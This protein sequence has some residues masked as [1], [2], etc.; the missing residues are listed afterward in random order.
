MP[1]QRATEGKIVAIAGAT[2]NAGRALVKEAKRRG[3][4][5]RALV[6]DETRLG[7]ARAS[8]DEIRVV[9]VTERESLRGALDGATYAL[10]ALGKTFQ[11]DSTPRREVDVDANV[12][13]FDEARRVRVRRAGLMSVYAAS[14]EHPAEIVRMKAQAEQALERSGVPF[15]IIQPSGFFSDM[16]EMF[17]MAEKGTLWAIGSEHLKLNP[18]A[19]SDLA[20]FT[21]DCLL[22]PSKEGTRQPVGGP[23]A[24]EVSE[25]GAL[26]GKIL[27]EGV[28]VRVVPV[29]LAKAGVGVAG[30]F[31]RNIGQIG[32]LFV[33]TA[34]WG[35]SHDALAPAHGSTHLEDY[36]R[37]R[38]QAEA[39]AKD[40]SPEP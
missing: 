19:M 26:F 5:V 38:W 13:V 36:L 12:N 7:D 21:I 29:W 17:E 22:D 40:G 28:H 23:D 8:C 20:A 33:E 3:L 25:L 4:V 37:R 11:K 14:L 34:A 31:S 39:A 9:E 27:G 15:V 1:E 10:S 24:Y 16:W 6:R 18:I 32:E 30:L 2:G 35:M